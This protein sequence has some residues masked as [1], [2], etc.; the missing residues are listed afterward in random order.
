MIQAR[1]IAVDTTSCTVVIGACT[2]RSPSPL[3]NSLR[4][5][6]QQPPSGSSPAPPLSASS[7]SSPTRTSQPPP[8]R[9]VTASTRQRPQHPAPQCLHPW[10][11]PAQTISVIGTVGMPSRPP[12][13]P[14]KRLMEHLARIFGR[15]PLKPI[16]QSPHHHRLPEV[17]HA[18]APSAPSAQAT[19]RSSPHRSPGTPAKTPSTPAQSPA[20]SLTPSIEAPRNL[21]VWCKGAGSPP[22]RITLRR[23]RVRLQK[24]Q[25]VIPPNQ[26]RRPGITQQINQI[27]AAPQQHMLR[28]DHLTQRRMLIGINPPPNLR[29]PLHQRHPCPILSATARRSRRKP[30]HT[31]THHNYVVEA[32]RYA[33]TSRRAIA[34]PLTSASIHIFSAVGTDTPA[35]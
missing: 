6:P 35:R 23:L 1:H 17:P 5:Q 29:P 16:V 8:T 12:R 20:L 9:A 19:P 32:H 30:S 4:H 28:I 22:A 34:P 3:A 26:L 25:L 2:S 11:L 18:P 10:P 33:P 7:T 15:A 13:R 24:H 31:S 21:I 27:R 14:Q